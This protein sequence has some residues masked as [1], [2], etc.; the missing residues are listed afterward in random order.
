MMSH[1]CESTVLRRQ[2]GLTGAVLLGLGAMLGTGVFVS[3]GLAAATAGAWLPAA[4]VLAGAVALCNGLSAAQLAAAY[5][6]SGGTYEYAYRTLTPALGF[7]AGWL[8]LVAK[9]ASAATAALALAGLAADLTGMPFIGQ[10]PVALAVTALFTALVAGGLRRSNRANSLLVG[11]TLAALSALV[12]AGLWGSPGSAPIEAAGAGGSP[13]G[14]LGA[15]ALMFVAFTGYGRIATLGEE[16]V[17][18][19]RV[20]PR[21]VIITMGVATALYIGVALTAMTVLSPA[22]LGRLTQTRGAPL[23]AVAYQLGGAGLAWFIA[24]AAITAMMGVL[25]NLLLGLSRVVLAMAR[26]CDLPAGLSRLTG[27]DPSPRAAVWAVG[28]MIGAWVCV[29]RI[30]VTWSFSAVTVLV[31]YAL[32]NLA[33]LRLGPAERL[34]PPGIP[35]AGLFGCLGLAVWIAPVYWLVA[36]GILLVGFGVRALSPR[37]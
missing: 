27:R 30:G 19:R 23:P 16:V 37:R 18:P 28:L 34:Y 36:A 17:A 8:F 15:A 3:I 31:Y 29:G 7:S 22:E 9:S 33:A 11:F 6:V 20:I 26:R 13:A 10:V 14:I 5:P 24:L 21:A 1:V 12:G 4:I 2:L 35:V 32:T 25:V